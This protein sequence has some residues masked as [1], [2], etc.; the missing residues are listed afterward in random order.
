MRPAKRLRSADRIVLTNSRQENG[1]ATWAGVASVRIEPLQHRYQRL[2][3]DRR[4]GCSLGEEELVDD[5]IGP[6][7]ARRRRGVDV[8]ARQPLAGDVPGHE[9]RPA[10]ADQPLAEPKAA[11]LRHR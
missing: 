11:A 1:L 6:R 2:A 7:A 3:P 5:A 9:P 4:R 10:L 8:V